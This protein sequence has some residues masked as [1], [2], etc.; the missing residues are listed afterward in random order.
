MDNGL[1]LFIVFTLYKNKGFKK[2]EKSNTVNSVNPMISFLSTMQ[3]KASY[4]NEKI[5]V[6]KKIGPYFPNEYI[7][8][9]NR[10]IFYT[11]RIVKFNE[12]IE[13]MKDDDHRYVTTTVN[14]DN[15]RDLV[16]KIIDTI[17]KEMP[18]K[19]DDNLGIFMDL[20]INKDKYK[21]MFNLLTSVTK[22][23]DCINDPAK[24]IEVLGPLLG[25]KEN[26]KDKV[27][28]MN[29]I[30]EIMNLLNTTKEEES[31]KKVI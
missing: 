31:D 1:L 2:N 4:T 11:E 29:K 14:V 23:P 15:N 27:K 20:I 16:S 10:S 9:L 5:K 17:Q 19:H 24:L 12:L 13:F 7:E 6:L 8:L 22:D 26:S 30:V 3:I 28:E 21:K 18:E 25:E